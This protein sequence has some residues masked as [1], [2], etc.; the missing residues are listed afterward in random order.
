MAVIKRH[1]RIAV[2]LNVVVVALLA[3]A[4]LSH[5]LS[6]QARAEAQAQEEKAQPLDPVTYSQIQ[7]IR[8]ALFLR[9]HDL[10]AMGASEQQAAAVL[11]GLLAWYE[12]N[13]ANLEQADGQV[14]QAQR[15]L[16]DA[17][18]QVNVG[19][20]DEGL[21]AQLPMLRQSHEQAV[22]QRQQLVESAVP[23]LSAQ[24]NSSQN[25]IWSS[26]R[27]NAETP[28]R[29]R[30]IPNLAEQ[31]K[32]TLGTAMS[33]F[34]VGSNELKAVEDRTLYGI[35]QMT[36]EQTQSNVRQ[37]MAGVLRAEAAVIPPPT[38]LAFGESAVGDPNEPMPLMP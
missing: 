27:A 9:S 13:K 12:L 21:L 10:A 18:R 6:R 25:E 35:Q 11:E 15:E 8:E 30:Y 26:A 7:M 31:E 23:G 32:R 36:L 38:E 1:W 29:Y 5:L 19:P 20:R 17:V 14:M 28:Q 3:G 4:I 16:R 34:G 2:M 24:L 37:H 22:Q 33:K